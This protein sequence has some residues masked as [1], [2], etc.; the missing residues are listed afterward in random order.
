MLWL[1][2]LEKKGAPL[3]SRALFFLRLGRNFLATV[4]I[5][6][7]SLA[8]GT[9]GYH[10]IGRIA[11]IDGFHNAAMILTGMG[12]VDKME[13]NA[14]KLFASFYALYSG[15]VFI[16]M[17]IILITPVYHRFIHRFHLDGEQ[18][19]ESAEAPKANG[20]L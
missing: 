8:F 19:Q 15:L 12:P 17:V 10:Y 13:S 1:S 20:T 2:H 14:G 6:A 18:L 3:A 11:W 16:T 7:F 9:V 5:I 4:G